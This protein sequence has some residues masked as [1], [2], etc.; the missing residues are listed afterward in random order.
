MIDNVT[1]NLMV[2]NR[3]YRNLSKTE[4]ELQI[5]LQQIYAS[6]LNGAAN[7]TA[8]DIYEAVTN[9]TI[10][11]EYG[12]ED[13]YW[14][15]KNLERKREPNREAFGEYYGRIMVLDEEGKEEGIM[16]IEEFLP[17]SK[18]HMDNLFRQMK[19]VD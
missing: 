6:E 13:D 7:N 14:F 3:N 19:E 15:N 10:E 12:H 2:Q 4:K 5:I 1:E 11:G 9:F 16:S 8:S 18:N 17:D